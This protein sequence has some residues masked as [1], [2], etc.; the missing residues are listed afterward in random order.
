MYIYMYVYIYIYVY[1]LRSLRHALR[2]ATSTLAERV[3]W[4]TKTSTFG[5]YLATWKL[6]EMAVKNPR[7]MEAN[8]R[9]EGSLK[10]CF[11]DHIDDYMSHL[12][13]METVWCCK[14]AVI[15]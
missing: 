4:T 11:S 15:S 8:G 12:D 6:Q 14:H 10:F 9:M 1:T 3:W 2:N 7:K 5:W 13:D